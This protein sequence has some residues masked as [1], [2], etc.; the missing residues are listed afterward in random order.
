MLEPADTSS[1]DVA[2]WLYTSGS[3]GNPKGSM[4]LMSDIVHT[5]VLYGGGILGITEQDVV[6]SAAKLFFAYGLG[7]GISFPFYVGATAV[8]MAERPTPDAVLS[9]LQRSKATI[10]C[11]VP[12][13]YGAIL[14]DPE[15]DH[16]RSS[17]RLRHCVSAGEALPEGVGRAWEERFEVPILD[18]LGST[19]PRL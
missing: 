4:H 17:P 10:Y 12:T 2:F 16:R 14:A 13:L 9:V 3:T 11:G 5:A 7:N 8:L 15:N 1:D 6:F 18:G 19:G